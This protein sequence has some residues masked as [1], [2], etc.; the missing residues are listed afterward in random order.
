MKSYDQ[1]KPL[2]L[3]TI[4]TPS[5]VFAPLSIY[6]S[7][8]S[9]SGGF[10]DDLVLEQYDRD[11]NLWRVAIASHQAPRLLEAMLRGLGDLSPTL[12]GNCL[13][14]LRGMI[15]R[16]QLRVASDE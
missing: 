7:G 13:R 8:G 9:E 16:R 15:R 5:T 6:F 4:V 2:L 3:P 14:E 10:C 12:Y 11:G 1:D